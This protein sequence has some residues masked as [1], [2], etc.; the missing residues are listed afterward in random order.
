MPLQ[1]CVVRVEWLSSSD[2]D[3]G[4]RGNRADTRVA[5]IRMGDMGSTRRADNRTAWNRLEGRSPI[6]SHSTEA[7]T[8]GQRKAEDNNRSFHR[9]QRR[10]IF[11]RS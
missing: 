5:D 9:I 10:L 4:N 6:R 2:G 11:P 7:A 3:D 1:H 8:T